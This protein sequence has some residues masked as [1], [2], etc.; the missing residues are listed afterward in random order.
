MMD[1]DHQGLYVVKPGVGHQ[2]G[3]NALDG[4]MGSGNDQRLEQGGQMQMHLQ[5]RSGYKENL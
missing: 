3:L 2:A 1:T 5:Y 4:M